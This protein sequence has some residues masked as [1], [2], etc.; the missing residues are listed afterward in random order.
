MLGASAVGKM[1]LWQ[2]ELLLAVVAIGVAVNLAT[3]C[4]LMFMFLF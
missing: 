3:V 4:Y 1:F 2:M